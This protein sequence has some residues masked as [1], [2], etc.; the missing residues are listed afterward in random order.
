MVVGGRRAFRRTFGAW[1]VLV[2]PPQ[3]PA[4]RCRIAAGPAFCVRCAPGAERAVREELA[5]RPDPRILA[6]AGEFDARGGERDIAAS[7]GRAV[8]APPVVAAGRLEGP[9]GRAVRAYKQDPAPEL[10]RLLAGPLLSWLDHPALSGVE[11]QLAP[12]PMAAVRR[13]ERGVNPAERL[14]EILARPP[15]RRVCRGALRRVR[16]RRPLRGLGAADRLREVAGAFAAAAGDRAGA[17]PAA[18]RRA[19]R[20]ALVDDV[21]TT[22]A[23]L[24][25]AAG[26]LTAAGH[27]PAVAFALG[28]TPRRSRRRRSAPATGDKQRSRHANV[29]NGAGA[30]ASANEGHV[31]RD[32][33]QRRPE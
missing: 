32:R 19:A 6:A 12:V 24:A 28:R 16:Y 31:P 20:F 9:W 5:R 7:A 18:G 33:H 29:R 10:G 30:G 15:A 25:A 22:G 1:K 4:C 27:S 26:A 14:A 13:R 11:L 3:C 17:G 21:F 23:T 8:A 2:V